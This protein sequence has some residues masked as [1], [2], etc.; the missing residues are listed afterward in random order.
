MLTGLTISAPAAR[1]QSLLPIAVAS[2]IVLCIHLTSEWRTHDPGRAAA[3]AS[4]CSSSPHQGRKSAP[5]RCKL[6]Q[7]V[8]FA[9]TTARN[10]VQ[11]LYTEEAKTR[12]RCKMT[13]GL[14]ISEARENP[15]PQLGIRAVSL[16][17]AIARGQESPGDGSRSDSDAIPHPLSI[18]LNQLGHGHVSAFNGYL[19]S[20]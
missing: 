13:I 10:S 7:P 2:I 5:A 17:S 18:S 8:C 15:H 16:P 9:R 1:V 3:V 4:S 14:T 19:K 6:P 11:R 12:S 20:A